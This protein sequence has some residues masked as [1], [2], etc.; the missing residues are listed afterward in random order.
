MNEKGSNG[1]KR[2]V[3][4]RASVALLFHNDFEPAGSFWGIDNVVNWKL[5][6]K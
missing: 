5:T 6:S 3:H 2:G 1:L 4:H